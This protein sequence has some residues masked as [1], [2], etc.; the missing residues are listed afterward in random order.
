MRSNS[1][2]YPVEHESATNFDY[3]NSRL[4]LARDLAEYGLV[5]ATREA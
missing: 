1:S 3:Q 4:E 5:K 2:G